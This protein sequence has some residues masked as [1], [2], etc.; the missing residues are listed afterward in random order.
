MTARPSNFA[1]AKEIEEE[2]GLKVKSEDIVNLS[3]LAVQQSEA[4]VPENNLQKGVYPSP[5]GLDEFISIFL[6]ESNDMTKAE[7]DKLRG[8]LTG[9]RKDGE[10]IKVNLHK[11]D[12]LWKVGARDGKTLA[13]YALYE[14]LSK[15]D[16]LEAKLQELREAKLQEG[17]EQYLD[18]A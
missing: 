10:K 6:W 1:A 9:E 8:K 3:E 13:A 17:R 4:N 11:Y 7:V 2:T 15:S 14:G 18:T 16:V 5:G 12:D